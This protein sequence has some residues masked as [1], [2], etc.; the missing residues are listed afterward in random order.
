MKMTA[1]RTRNYLLLTLDAYETLFHPRLPIATQYAQTAR[2][3]GAFNTLPAHLHPSDGD[4]KSAFKDAFKHEAKL[5]PNYG[6]LQGDFT[7]GPRQWWAN[8]IKGTF[9][10][11][12]IA[13][14][15]KSGSGPRINKDEGKDVN[16]TKRHALESL[17][18]ELV[19]RLVQRFWSRE[20][21]ELYDD[22]EPFFRALRGWKSRIK[23]GIRSEDD[24]FDQIIVGVVSNS[25]DRVPDILKSLGLMV[26]DTRA[27]GTSTEAQSTLE[28]N[29]LAKSSESGN[30]IEFVITSYEAGEEK[31]HRQI[32][33]VAK[34]RG[35][36]CKQTTPNREDLE[37]SP[38]GETWTY[39]HVGDDEA[40]DYR[41]AIDAGWD[42]VYLDRNAH[43]TGG[44]Y[45]S[46]DIKRI[47]SLD[48][49]LPKIGL[50]AGRD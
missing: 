45:E 34:H 14:T 22:V 31:P 8:V 13:M 30:D 26:G 11:A 32:F 4:L 16:E 29:G 48:E 46:Q 1:K 6:R 20:G 15:E 9:E 37:D 41:G 43:E 5:R 39:V 38:N 28:A 24:K 40:K 25:D 21:Y 49:L 35:K 36:A 33:D 3:L 23:Q 12:V 47:D 50:G 42:S 2:F 18:P 17:P 27:E 44:K 7:G 19:P 10:R